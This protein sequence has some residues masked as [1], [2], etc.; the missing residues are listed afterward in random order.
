MS[1]TY[2]KQRNSGIREFK[3][4]HCA[5]PALLVPVKKEAATRT[6]TRSNLTRRRNSAAVES[7]KLWQ[8]DA[9]F[10]KIETK[11]YLA[12]GRLGPRIRGDADDA[13]N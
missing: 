2:V 6:R 4:C 1:Q 5:I 10:P 13:E 7:V 12:G 3:I 9:H 11:F 8:F